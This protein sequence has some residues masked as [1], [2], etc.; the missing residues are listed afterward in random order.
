MGLVS[1]IRARFR[2]HERAM[3]VYRLLEP[4]VEITL[5]ERADDSGRPWTMVIVLA[6]RSQQEIVLRTV[7]EHD[8]VTFQEATS[9]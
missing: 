2:T 1:E 8:G 4:I 9:G 5:P 6:N 3:Q 7:R